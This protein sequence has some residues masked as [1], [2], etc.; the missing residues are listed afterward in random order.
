VSDADIIDAS[1]TALLVL[2]IQPVILEYVSEPDVLLERVAR[3]IAIARRA[4]IQIGY[5]RIGFA[6][7]DYAEIPATNKVLAPVA[8]AVGAMHA[9]SAE[10]AVHDKVA[11]QRG[12][13]VVRKT[14]V[15]AFSTT[16]LDRQLRDRGIDTL[17]LAGITTSGVVLS[18]MRDAVDRDYAVYILADATADTETDVHELLTRKVFPT[19]AHVISIDGLSH[20]LR[21]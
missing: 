21:S 15:G 19:H 7:S 5:V 16:D 4:G 13:I 11:P 12:D 10:T 20:L 17:I 18:T 9:D 8:G 6:D 2:D 1:H 3:V 14:R